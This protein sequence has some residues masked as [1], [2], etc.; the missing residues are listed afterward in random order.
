M[1]ELNSELLHS[2]KNKSFYLRLPILIYFVY[3][4]CGHLNRYDYESIL[5][6]LNLGTYELGHFVF[7]WM[8]EFMGILGGLAFQAGAPLVA[9]LNFYYQGDF[10]ALFFSFGWLST[11]LFLIAR[12]VTDARIMGIPLLGPFTERNLSYDWNYFLTRIGL[13]PYARFIT[14]ICQVL[15]CLA[16]FICFIG[17]LWFLIHTKKNSSRA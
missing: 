15:A 3:I 2:T 8:G 17:G 11:S 6:P 4:F 16:M 12:Y 13:L 7:S 1:K 5:H 9:I 10:F 14:F